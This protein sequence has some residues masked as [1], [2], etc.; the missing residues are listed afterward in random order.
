MAVDRLEHSE[1]IDVTV[2]AFVT[3]SERPEDDDLLRSEAFD[4][5]VDRGF[6]PLRERATAPN[7]LPF[8]DLVS[9]S[10]HGRT[11]SLPATPSHV[12]GAGG[13]GGR[14]TAV[15]P[16]SLRFLIWALT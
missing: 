7:R 2:G 4:D 14:Y 6:K 13:R 12:T 11:P 1:E 16:A 5:A 8:D 15:W 9:E 10:A 3:S